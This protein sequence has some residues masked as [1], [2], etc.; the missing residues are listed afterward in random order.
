MYGESWSG[1]TP[2]A[3]KIQCA[4]IKEEEKKSK[5]WQNGKGPMAAN[6][7]C[8]YFAVKYSRNPLQMA[9]MASY[10][11]CARSAACWP[12]SPPLPP[13]I[14]WKNFM[15]FEL[16]TFIFVFVF[17]CVN[18]INE[19]IFIWHR[20]KIWIRRYFIRM[21]TLCMCVRTRYP[22]NNDISCMPVMRK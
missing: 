20:K 4:V 1:R 13:R 8:C 16:Q 14:K 3:N 6:C 5:K 19:N 2:A 15:K 11:C 17:F 22:N 21:C 18:L 10:I 7:C 9:Q 12:R